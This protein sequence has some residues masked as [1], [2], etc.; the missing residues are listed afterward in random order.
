[1]TTTSPYPTTERARGGLPRW[2]IPV[3]IIAVPLLLLLFTFIGSRN[4]LVNKDEA[5]NQQFGQ[6][7]VAQQRRFDLIPGLVNATK[8][9]LN[10]E[11]KVFGDI[12]NARARLGGARTEND[13][14]EASNQLESTLSRLLVVVE[15]YPQLQSNQTVQNLMTQLEGTENRIAQERRGYNE[16][17]TEYNRSIRRFP[18]SIVAGMSGFERR[19][20][21]TGKQGSQDPPAV[22]LDL[23][24]QPAPAPS[25]S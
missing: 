1:M 16:V 8:A 7:E 9:V 6:V 20:L 13:K 10:Q 2:V 21:F 14:V 22:N 18:T 19:T 3:A 23:N 11:Q 17:V 5:V 4:G 25:E 24:S 15:N 12:A